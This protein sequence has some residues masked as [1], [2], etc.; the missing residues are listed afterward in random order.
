MIQKTI[1]E[2]QR[3][4]PKKYRRH[5]VMQSL[6]AGAFILLVF[7]ASHALGCGAVAASVGA[8]TMIAFAF[9][10]AESSKYRYLLGGYATAIVCGLLAGGGLRLAGETLFFIPSHPLFCALAV[11]AAFFL[12]VFLDFQ[13]PPAA[14]LAIIVTLSERPL[15]PAGQAAAC[16]VLL[17]VIKKLLYKR[18]INL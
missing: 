9:P 17:C 1:T 7:L 16:I 2:L 4:N 6:L 15:I 3:T 5:V 18:L 10:R 12:M 11:C 13:H 14:A 8:S